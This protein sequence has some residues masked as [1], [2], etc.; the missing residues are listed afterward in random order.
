MAPILWGLLSPYSLRRLRMVRSVSAS[1]SVAFNGLSPFNAYL[2]RDY[3]TWRFTR[4]W[5]ASRLLVDDLNVASVEHAIGGLLG[6]D[7][8][9][10]ESWRGPVG[11]EDFHSPYLAVLDG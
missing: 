7:G 4:G 10:H 11:G 2:G 9:F 3:M 1:W 5:V 8:V 6:A